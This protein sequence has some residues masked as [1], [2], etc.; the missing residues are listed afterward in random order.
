MGCIALYNLHNT[1]YKKT[2]L[3]NGLRILTGSMPHTRS[4]SICIYVGVG[5]RYEEDAQAGAS[6]YLEHM[7]F[8]GTHKRPSSV[9]ITGAIEGVGGLMNG[10]TDRELTSFW[11]KVARPHFYQALDVLIDMVHDPLLE[12][13]EV[14]KERTVVQEE[15]AMS[16][17]HPS[18]RVDMLTDHMLWPNQPMGRDIGGTKESV[19]GISQHSNQRCRGLR[20]RVRGVVGVVARC[21]PPHPRAQGD[22]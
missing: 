5:S 7:L 13:A 21:C 4:V 15:L 19:E 3:D 1:M 9:Q 20:R 17:D 2:T 18:Y 6:H 16:N 12:P 10:A 22:G 11:C 8:K 14:E